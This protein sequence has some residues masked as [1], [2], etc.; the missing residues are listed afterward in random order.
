MGF[1]SI[2]ESA[3]E[4]TVEA[5][6]VS[7]GRVS[8]IA[9]T[10]RLLE[11]WLG[12]ISGALLDQ[13]SFSG[14]N[15][16]I[17]VLLA[18]HMVPDDFGAYVV[19]FAWFQLIQNVYD[20]FLSEPLV[21]F[22]SGKYRERFRAYLGHAFRGH[23]LFTIFAVAAL[24]VIT[25]AAYQFDR[26]IVALAL[27]GALIATPL[28]LMRWL[29]KAPLY[30]LGRPHLAAVMNALYLGIVVGGVFLLDGVGLLSPF[31]AMLLLGAGILPG[32]LLLTFRVLKPEWKTRDE[33]AYRRA[34]AEHIAYGKWSVGYRLLNWA[35]SSAVTLLTSS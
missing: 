31:S 18:R 3:I 4:G 27:L 2:A 12:R 17:N 22:G 9:R 30:A 7:H 23:A 13:L 10:K 28:I 11:S 5:G 1:E 14:A 20:A 29:A 19:A 26:R 33:A 6:A 15:F 24:G 34:L 21:I 35:P 32:A 25:L 16:L 8:L